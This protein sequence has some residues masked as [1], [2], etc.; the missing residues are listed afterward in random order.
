MAR[1]EPFRCNF[2]RYLAERF[3]ELFDLDS[4][5]HFY[6]FLSRV[7]S[8]EREPT[9]PGA[10]DNNPPFNV[11]SVKSEIEAWQQAFGFKRIGFN[12]VFLVVPRINWE[13]GRVYDQYDDD[14]NLFGPEEVKQFYVLVDGR[15]VYKCLG[16]NFGGIS[17]EKPTGTSTEAFVRPNDQYRWKFLYRVPEDLRDFLT[18]DFMPVEFISGEGLLPDERQLQFNVQEAAIDGSI[19][20]ID[21]ISPGT[22]DPLAYPFSV[23]PNAIHFVQR[24]EESIVNTDLV[25]SFPLVGEIELAGTA[26]AVDDAYNNMV[27]R[28]NDGAGAGEERIILDWD[29]ATKIATLNLPF[30]VSVLTGDTYEVK[31]REMKGSS[32]LSQVTD[33]F[34]GYVLTIVSGP[35]IGQQRDIIGYDGPTQIFTLAAP[36]E[37]DLVADANPALSSFYTVTPKVTIEGDGEGATATAIVDTD[38]IIIQIN[39]VD[40]GSG[41]TR[42]TVEVG[43]LFPLGSPDPAVAE[44]EISPP[45]GHGSNPVKELCA[46]RALVVVRTDQ[47]ELGV[48]QVANDFRQFGIVR[49]PVLNDG[50]DRLAGEEIDPQLRIEVAWDGA[51]ALLTGSFTVGRSVLGAVSGAVGE[52]T[53]WTPDGS[54]EAGVLVIKN[55][56]SQD[57]ILP[58]GVN[59]G[60]FLHQ[61]DATPAFTDL[62]IATVVLVTQVILNTPESYRQSCQL[63]LQSDG[64][65]TNQLDD[66]SFALDRI[67]VGPTLRQLIDSSVY[68][69][70]NDLVVGETVTGGISGAT[71]IVVTWT[72]ATVGQPGSV[73]IVSNVVG[74][75]EDGETLTGGTSG[76]TIDIAIDGQSEFSTGA[77]GI[78]VQWEPAVDG[79]TGVL[80]LVDVRGEFE[81]NSQISEFDPDT[82]TTVSD[83]AKVTGK[84]DPELEHRSGELLYIQNVKP[85]QRDIEQ[86]EEFK[87]VV[88]F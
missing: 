79:L 75:F 31:S 19:D 39:V 10:D 71:G 34:N 57:F 88:E 64:T 41:Y 63:T 29:G 49:N 52:I 65:V 5:D 37:A 23:P 24:D 59:P 70:A 17:T 28:I 48:F 76:F 25:Q 69:A 60:E 73:V 80:S 78:I 40:R 12:D 9:D 54:G 33:V 43:P 4:N 51:N 83:I 2:R 81:T 32:N 45:G 38:G 56:T 14:V 77:T 47:D 87:I 84:T 18:E 42:A 55:P 8:W 50:T 74:V 6:L 30:S 44:A 1:C 62:N 21:L 82:D 7:V 36:W 26:S 3:K 22:I 11:D 86:A 53:D 27:L 68:V 61:F 13:P 67:A 35:G 46:R 20:F 85:I 15:D 58:E 16:N 66:A 72:P